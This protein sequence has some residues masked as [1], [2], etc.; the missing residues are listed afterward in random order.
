MKIK[1]KKGQHLESHS[2]HQGFPVNIW[3]K[4]N[5]G[6]EVEVEKIPDD[7]VDKVEEVVSSK[8]KKGDK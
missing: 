7:A 2:S 5:S 6:E 1:L 8:K 3:R 4:L